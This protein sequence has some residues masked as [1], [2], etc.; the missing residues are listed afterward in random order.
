MNTNP[1][2]TDEQI[3]RFARFGLPRPLI[4]DVGKYSSLYELQGQAKAQTK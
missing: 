1:F 2:L 3:E 4:P